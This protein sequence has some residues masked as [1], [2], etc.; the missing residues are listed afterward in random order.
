MRKPRISN[1]LRSLVK[2]GRGPLSSDQPRSHPREGEVVVPA[3]SC[4]RT[5]RLGA[6]QVCA[7]HVRVQFTLTPFLFQL[8]LLPFSPEAPL[9]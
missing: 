6:H 3:R 9:S 2:G 5:C 4:L 8:L 7:Q 1:S